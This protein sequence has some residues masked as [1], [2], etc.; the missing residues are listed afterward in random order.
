[1]AG[2]ASMS[3]ELAI[4]GGAEAAALGH[5]S[6]SW[7][8]GASILASV[9]VVVSV[10]QHGTAWHSV[11]CNSAWRALACRPSLQGPC[12]GQTGWPGLQGRLA[13]LGHP[14]LPRL[15][16][17]GSPAVATLRYLHQLAQRCTASPGIQYLV[18]GI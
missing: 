1:M 2:A 14:A 10:A 5:S 9:V 6:S 7:I 18:P 13:G 17:I 15:R 11:T 3:L 8:E 4:N 16:R 12:R